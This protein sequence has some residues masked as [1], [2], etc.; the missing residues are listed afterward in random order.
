MIDN[1]SLSSSNNY[2]LLAQALYRLPWRVAQHFVSIHNSGNTRCGIIWH[3]IFGSFLYHCGSTGWIITNT[4]RGKPITLQCTFH[5][6]IQLFK[7]SN[8]LLD[9]YGSIANRFIYSN[10]L[11][12]SLAIERENSPILAICYGSHNVWSKRTTRE[13]PLTGCKVAKRSLYSK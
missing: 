5:Y 4:F 2:P 6:E 1:Q 10:D 7:V 8:S 12:F 3:F 11:P 9:V 13:N